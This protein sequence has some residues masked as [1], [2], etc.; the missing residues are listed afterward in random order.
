[1]RRPEDRASS[2]TPSDCPRFVASS[3]GGALPDILSHDEPEKPRYVEVK[4][5]NGGHASSF[6]ISRN[7]LDFAAQHEEDFHLHRILQFGQAPKLHV[8]HGRIA[9]RLHLEPIDFR[10]SFRRWRT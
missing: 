2:E 7:E 4:T 5:S 9:D 3:S 10:A 1:M 6:V 8:L